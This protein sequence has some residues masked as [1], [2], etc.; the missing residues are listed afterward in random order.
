MSR[1][2]PGVRGP[3]GPPPPGGSPKPGPSAPVPANAGALQRISLPILRVLTRMPR[4]LLV[5][6]MA[7]LLFLGLI[8]TGSLAWLGAVL[9][10]IVTLFFIWLL[11][12]SWPAVPPSGR[13]L[14][15]FI[16]AALIVATALKAMGRL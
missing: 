12:L 10:G 15:G 9:L 3:G 8:Q 1:E 2:R 16:V 7:V 5:V 11:V 14:R 6:G 4:W 13:I